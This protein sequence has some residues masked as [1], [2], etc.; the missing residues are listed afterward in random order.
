M[1]RIGTDCHALTAE[2]AVHGFEFQQG[3]LG[4]AFRIVTPGTAQVAALQKDGGADPG[5]VIGA[6]FLDIEYQTG[7]IGR[8]A[9]FHKRPSFLFLDF[10]ISERKYN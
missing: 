5:A 7:G 6:E 4:Q 8:M 2:D 9:G 10:I 1:Y 3:S